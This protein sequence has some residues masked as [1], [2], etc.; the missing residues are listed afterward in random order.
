MKEYIL[1]PAVWFDDGKQY[2][3]QPKNVNSG[4]VLCGWRHHSIFPQIDIGIKNK[5]EIG[6]Y[7]REQGFITNLNR[8]IGREESA[9]IA[10]IA[11]QIDKPVKKLFSED[12]Y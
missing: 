12:L 6:I 2:S 10:Y 7:E 11:N 3:N 4:V 8:F 9:K 1:C 5:D